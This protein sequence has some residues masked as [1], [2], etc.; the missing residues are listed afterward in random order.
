MIKIVS[1]DIYVILDRYGKGTLVV[2]GIRYACTL[3]LLKRKYMLTF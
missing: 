1:S 3:K 2:V